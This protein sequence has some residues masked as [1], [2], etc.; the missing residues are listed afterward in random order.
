MKSMRLAVIAAASVT[1]ASLSL[2][3]A[4]PA[5]AES[6][7]PYE[8]GDY[9]EVGMITVDDGHDLDYA[10]FLAGQ[11]KRGQD[12]AK[13]QG[14]ITGYEVLYNTFKRDGEPDIYLMT[15]T[16][17]LAD[18]AEGMRRDEAYRAFMQRT[19][20]QLQ[21]ESGE[22]AKYRRQMGA[23]LLRRVDWKK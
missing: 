10:K 6:E 9:G 21:A 4:S 20:S 18:K 19:E 15:Y 13:Q 22:R 5:A 12:H 23:M 17:R 7:Y 1:L 2:A 8:L 3:M 14:W 11:W 16:P